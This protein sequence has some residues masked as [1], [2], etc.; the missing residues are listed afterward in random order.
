MDINDYSDYVWKIFGDAIPATNL[1]A[2]FGSLQAGAIQYS[3]DPDVIQALSA[4]GKGWE[5]A[6]IESYYPAIQ[7]M[8]ALYYLMSRQLAYFRQS[9]IPE[10]K[11]DIEYFIGSIVSD[12]LGSIYKS[13][14]NNNLNQAFTNAAK[15][16]LV[17]S[18]KITDIGNVYYATNLDY[19]IHYS[20][21][22]SSEAHREIF[23]PNPSAALAGRRYN[24]LNISGVSRP[25][26]VYN[27]KTT[28]TFNTC[29]GVYDITITKDYLTYPNYCNFVCDG[30]TWWAL[31]ATIS[32]P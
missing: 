1:M 16:F 4:F 11:A 17:H 12:G 25:L 22:D 9:G 27:V 19:N 32:L 2:Q 26:V 15:W 10:W 29:I 6:V 18:T 30:S 8:N 7:D 20:L 5:S 21:N 14:I 24:I 28:N 3:K 31:N 13:L 23:L